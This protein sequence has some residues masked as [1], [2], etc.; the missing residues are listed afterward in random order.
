MRRVPD[1]KDTLYKFL[2]TLEDIQCREGKHYIHAV[3]EN[4]Y[5]TGRENPI[6]KA[7]IL[8][9]GPI[10]GI[11]DDQYIKVGKV[12]IPPSWLEEIED[13]IPTEEPTTMFD[14]SKCKSYFKYECLN[15]SEVTVLVNEAMAAGFQLIGT[16]T[17]TVEMSTSPIQL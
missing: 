4:D 16:N 6:F 2:Y 8:E 5:L 12:R 1:K 11:V 14:F 17:T 10:Q 3:G 9:G 13:T 15:Y 7:M